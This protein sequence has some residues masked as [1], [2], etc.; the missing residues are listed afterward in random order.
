MNCDNT[1]QVSKKH[2]VKKT[3]EGS[4]KHGGQKNRGSKKHGGLI[5]KWL[6]SSSIF[7]I[8]TK[9]AIKLSIFNQNQQN[10][11]VSC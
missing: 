2:G 6:N 10:K 5:F 11:N 3:L 7:Y 8:F 4:K 1:I 9:I